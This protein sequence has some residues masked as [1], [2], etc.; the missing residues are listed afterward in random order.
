MSD[1]IT[2]F[3]RASVANELGISPEEVSPDT[4]F[5][6]MGMTSLSAVLVSGV[7]EDEYDIEIE[8]SILFENRTLTTVSAALRGLLEDAKK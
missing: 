2:N 7:I 4:D 8:P 6:E 1:D 5:E 3:L